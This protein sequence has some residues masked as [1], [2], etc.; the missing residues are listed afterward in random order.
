MKIKKEEVSMCS[1]QILCEVDAGEIISFDD[2]YWIVTGSFT[3]DG[4]RR[5][6]ELTTGALMCLER[7]TNVELVTH[8]DVTVYEE[9]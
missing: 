9:V 7:T 8:Y 1:F 6:V 5:V 3:D 2:S 4:Y